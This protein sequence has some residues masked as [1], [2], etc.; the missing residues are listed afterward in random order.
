MPPSGFSQKAIN[1]LLEFVRD[2][3]VAALKGRDVSDLNEDEFL[4]KTALSMMVGFPKES[5]KGLIVFI[6]ECFKDLKREIKEGSDKHGREV[7]CGEAIEKELNQI[8]EYLKKF[9]I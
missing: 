4:E 1:G 3:Y 9:T 2:N 5:H 6:S 8:G 7:V